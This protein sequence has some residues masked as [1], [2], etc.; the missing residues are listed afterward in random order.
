MPSFEQ[1]A[2]STSN[3]KATV[4]A[5][6]LDAAI[7]KYLEN[8]HSPSRKVNEPDNRTA[9][10]YLSLYWAEALAAQN[11]DSPLKD[12]FTSISAQ[13][14]EKKDAIVKELLDAQGQSVELG[15]YFR[16]DASITAQ[17]MRPSATLNAILDAAR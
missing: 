1:I 7:A 12:R 14:G 16:P 3:G 8:E 15:G 10:F 2:R 17:T 13:L 5:Q 4:L 9:T 6:T 11:D